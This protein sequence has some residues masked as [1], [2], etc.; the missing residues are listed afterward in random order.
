MQRRR[1]RGLDDFRLQTLE[2]GHVAFGLGKAGFGDDA[3]LRLAA[4]EP[5]A[6]R[7]GSDKSE[8]DDEGN[9][10]AAS[11]ARPRARAANPLT[12]RASR[13]T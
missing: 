13:L 4:V 11:L 2:I 3:A 6:Q 9:V 12:S 7:G 1:G 10:H 8:D 5:K